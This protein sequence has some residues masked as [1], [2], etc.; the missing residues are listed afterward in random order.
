MV[1]VGVEV[2]GGDGSQ[3]TGEKGSS[4]DKL[5]VEALNARD[6]Y[7]DRKSVV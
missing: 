4:R 3:T 2:G 7:G 6:K 1:G 5:A